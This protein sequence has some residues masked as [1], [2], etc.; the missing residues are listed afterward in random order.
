MVS[1]KIIE[2]HNGI[3]EVQSKEGIGTTFHIYLP[4]NKGSEE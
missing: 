4:I 2:E 1:Y 3:I